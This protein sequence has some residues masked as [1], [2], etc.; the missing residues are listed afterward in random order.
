MGARRDL[1]QAAWHP[2]PSDWTAGARQAFQSLLY[3]GDASGQEGQE[4]DIPSIETL[5]VFSHSV[6]DTQEFLLSQGRMGL[7]QCLLLCS[8]YW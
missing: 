4:P 7:P 3:G 1:L 6:A 5:T 8:N 2:M